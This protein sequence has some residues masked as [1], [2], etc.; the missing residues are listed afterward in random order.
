[1]TRDTAKYVIA[2]RKSVQH[3]KDVSKELLH[4]VAIQTSVKERHA[5]VMQF[6]IF[7]QWTRE[8]WKTSP[9][10]VNTVRD[11]LSHFRRIDKWEHAS[12]FEN[13]LLPRQA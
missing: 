1:M 3:W 11:K 5:Q 6:F 12:Y 13:V 10:F 4:R 2:A 9:A 7:L 8:V